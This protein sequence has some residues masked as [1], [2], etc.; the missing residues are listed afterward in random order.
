MSQNRDESG[1]YTGKIGPDDVLAALRSHPEPVATAADIADVLD[2]TSETVRR[3]LTELREQGLVERKNVGARAVVWWITQTDTDGAPAAP[4]R[5][6]VGML[7]GDEADRARE[8]SQ[9]WRDAFDEEMAD[10]G[11]A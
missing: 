5:R 1:Q 9:E 10:A 4:L 6:L 7:D 11:D 2:V 8:R 3:R